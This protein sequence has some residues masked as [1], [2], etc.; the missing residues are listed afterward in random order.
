MNKRIPTLCV[1]ALGA[2]TATSAFAATA[3]SLGSFEG[4]EEPTVRYL[5]S[6][7]KFA[8]GDSYVNITDRGSGLFRFELLFRKN[9]WWDGDRNTT[10]T[11]RGRAEV[12]G[13]GAHQKNNETFEYTQT[14]R[15]DANW[16]ASG[17]FCHIFQ[18]KTTDTNSV[19][20]NLKADTNGVARFQNH[21]RSNDT[22]P[23]TW[24]YSVNSF[25]TVKLRIKISTSSGLA[26]ASVNGDSFKGESGKPN[27]WE[28]AADYRPKW[29]LY[30][31]Q[32]ND[33]NLRDNY[34]EDKA[35]SAT[36]I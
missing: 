11:D 32:T 13:I 34:I 6:S 14:W 3:S 25:Q 12:K 21:S 28:G 29:G 5:V 22:T 36:K 4:A 16:V 35:V 17:Q 15:T 30:R 33:M 1:L 27:Y 8:T 19:M 26:Q 18:L 9:D 2:M 24:N 23:R 31:K 10:L 20:S 7:K